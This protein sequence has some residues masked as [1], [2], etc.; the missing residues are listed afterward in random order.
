M[1][2]YA[3]IDENNIVT[4]VIV[5]KDETDDFCDWEE[6]YQRYRPG[7]RCKRTS[8][9]TI[10]NVHINGGIPFRKN[11]AAVGYSYDDATD[12]FIP[13]KPFP[14]WILNQESC[15]WNPPIPYPDG[16][17]PYYWD[18]FGQTWILISPPVISEAETTQPEVLPEVDNTQPDN[19]PIQE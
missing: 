3:F 2:H 15:I 16:D 10:G 18:E 9:N 8:Y 5:G 14:S 4:E 17:M 6:Y 11:F 19:Q 1:A 7:M 13:Q 12:S